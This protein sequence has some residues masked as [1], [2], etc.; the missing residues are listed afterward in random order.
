MIYS[1]IHKTFC[2]KS[3]HQNGNENRQ[4]AVRPQAV[5]N[6][7]TVVIDEDLPRSLGRALKAR[8]H[9]VFDIRDYGLRGKSD[10]DIFNFAQRQGAVLFSGDLGFANILKF[11]LGSHCGIAVLRFPNDIT[12]DV[13]N[14]IVLRFLKKIREGDLSGNLIIFSPNRMRLKRK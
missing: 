3:I 4:G 14:Q 13:M 6:R 7:M 12:T 2:K 10:E 11:P 9:E 1:D 5:S 8:G